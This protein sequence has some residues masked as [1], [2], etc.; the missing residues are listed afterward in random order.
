[1]KNLFL[2]LF[3]I[4]YIF[5]GQINFDKVPENFQLFPRDE[6]NDSHVVLSGNI[7]NNIDFEELIL[8]IFKDNVLIEKKSI[9]ILNKKFSSISIIKAGLFHYKFE[10]FKK[11]DNKE[12]LIYLADNI[13]SGDAYLIT[14][15]SNSHASHIK[16]IYSNRYARSFGVKTGYETYSEN[17]KKIRW[18]LATGNCKD[19]KS[20]NFVSGNDGAW[21]VKNSYGVGVWGME[22]AKLLIEKYKIPVC[23]INGGSGSSTIEENMLYPEQI[24][25]ETSFGRLAYRTDQAGLKNDIKA[26]FYHQG[27]SDTYKKNSLAYTDNFEIL[28]NDWNRVYKGVKKI[29]LF[30]IHPGCGGDYQSEIREIQNMIYKKYND[31]EIMSTTAILGHDGC[32]FSFEGYKEF[33]RRILPLVSRDFFDEKPSAIITPPQL[34][35]TYYSGNKEITL[36]FDQPVEIEQYYELNGI[37]Y[38]MNNQ[39]FFSSDNKTT[40]VQG[41]VENINAK[42]NKIIIK[43]KTVKKYSYVSWMP[44]KFYENSNKIYNGPWIKGIENNIGALSFFK[45]KI[46]Q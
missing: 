18:G 20:D 45:R 10:L 30:Q 7:S 38:L 24:S 21:F 26:I 23:I 32:H 41:V 6:N 8:K 3:L 11:Q 5:I 12:E 27:E 15:Q 36:S 22:L 35:K 2:I 19:C 4:P 39:F 17:D 42:K 37:K 1:M 31:V 44:G 43:L 28:K 25:L 14:G 29:Y 33:A 13:V 9:E 16:S 40:T 34:L 46:N